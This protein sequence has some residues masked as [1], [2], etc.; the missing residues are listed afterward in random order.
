MSRP[1]FR[2]FWLMFAATVA[3]AVACGYL[4]AKGA[5]H[6][7]G[8]MLAAALI[9]AVAAFG[10]YVAVAKRRQQR[11]APFIRPALRTDDIE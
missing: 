3:C 4:T 7:A 1:T 6:L 5:V 2:P 11:H 8:V 10:E 9:F